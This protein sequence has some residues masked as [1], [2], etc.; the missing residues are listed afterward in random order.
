MI[1]VSIKK[2]N[3]IISEITIEGH[4][5]YEELGKDIVCAAVSSISITTVN[6]LISI[7][8]GCIVYTNDDGFLKIEIKKHDQII[9][10]LINNM[11]NLLTELEKDYKKKIEIR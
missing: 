10:K 4:S 8:E 11:I 6:A 9:D 1:K 2:E 7:D 3:G 5:G